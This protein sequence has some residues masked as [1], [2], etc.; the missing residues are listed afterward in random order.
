M[1]ERPIRG[2]A[3]TVIADRDSAAGG[4][5]IAAEELQHAEILGQCV[6]CEAGAFLE[7]GLQ[8][9]LPVVAVTRNEHRHQRHQQKHAEG[10]AD[11]GLHQAYAALAGTVCHVRFLPCHD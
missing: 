3:A 10:G 1:V 11:H 9:V 7:P 2:A 6:Q 4:C 5:D 8:E